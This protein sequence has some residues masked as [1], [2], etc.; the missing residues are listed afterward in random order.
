ML[1]AIVTSNDMVTLVW[2]AAKPREWTFRSL[3]TELELD[4]AA[5]HRSVSRLKRARLIDERRAPIRA[6]V[7]EFLVHALRY[8]APAE[9]GPLGRGVPTA[10]GAPPLAELLAEDGEPAPV[11]P[12]PMGASRGPI[13]EPFAEGVPRLAER[14]REMA[15]WF[16][17][18]D[19]I[20]IGRARER[21]LAA[22]LLSERIWA[23]AESRA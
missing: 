20:R 21:Q 17:L 9:P 23:T 4:P 22:E 6:N 3:G 13:V 12:D 11:W 8:L 16:A 10:W 7:E 14:D 18:L 5:L 1:T 19:A 15:E 2:L